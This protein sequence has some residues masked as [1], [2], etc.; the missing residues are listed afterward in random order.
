L[1]DLMKQVGMPNGLNAVGITEDD[2]DQM[3]QGT[4]PQSRIT[5]LSPRTATEDD[6]RDIFRQSMTI[7]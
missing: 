2:L 5:Q 6:Y 4:L 1:I 7:W 3:V